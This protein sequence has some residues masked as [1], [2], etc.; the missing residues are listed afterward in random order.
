MH[1]EEKSAG[2]I[3]FSQSY[4]FF[5]ATDHGGSRI[6][7]KAP[8]ANP[9]DSLTKQRIGARFEGTEAWFYDFGSQLMPITDFPG[10]Q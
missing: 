10:Q 4:E 3:C 8:I 5:W 1:S 7:A 6:V 2:H 9:L